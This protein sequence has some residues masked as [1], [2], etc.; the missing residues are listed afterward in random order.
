MAA[1]PRLA[2]VVMLAQRLMPR[3]LRILFG[4]VEARANEAARADVAGVA[5]D[6]IAAYA[7]SVDLAARSRKGLEGT[8]LALSPARV[9][10]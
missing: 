9:V 5:T 10:V 1:P 3:W 8:S 4:A 7:S 6:V 2:V